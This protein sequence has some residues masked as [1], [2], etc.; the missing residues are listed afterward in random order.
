MF[1]LSAVSVV[2]CRH[3]AESLGIGVAKLLLNALQTDKSLGG[4]MPSAVPG[5]WQAPHL[6]NSE[7][8]MSNFVPHQ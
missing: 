8:D 2:D 3:Q 6:R 5:K 4:F 1:I 7:P